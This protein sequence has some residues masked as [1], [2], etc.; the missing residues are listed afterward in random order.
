MFPFLSRIIAKLYLVLVLLWITGLILYLIIISFKIKKKNFNLK[1]IIISFVIEII[2]LIII[3]SVLP[4]EYYVKDSIIYTYGAS[5]KFIY[6]LCFLY[7]IIG[8]IILILNIKNI[9]DNRYIPLLVLVV[10]GG[11]SAII[12]MIYPGLLLATSVHVFITF[13]MYFTIENPDME[14][15]NKL[16][17][18]YNQAEESNNIKSDFLSSM[19]H[20]INTPLNAI[21]GFSQIMNDAK[22]LKEA[23]ENSKYVL[24]ASFTLHNM[25]KNAIDLMGI[26]NNNL[27]IEFEKY[28][29]KSEINK[30]VSLYKKRVEDKN[31]RLNVK[32]EVPKMLYG[33][34]KK[35]RR[36]IANLLD[37]AIKYTDEGSI[38][39]TINSKIENSKCEL[40][41]IVKD[42]GTGIDEETQKHLFEYFEREKKYVNG[43]K[44]GMGLGLPI[45]KGLVELL[46]GKIECNSNEKGTTFNIK[47]IQRKG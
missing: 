3:I 26:G 19:S 6:S 47:I 1:L 28:D 14:M 21:M 37:N 34:K 12:Q 22:T 29:L 24:D 27:S 17:L 44:S 4:I 35:V 8:I 41:I 5:V 7:T 38:Y 9:A 15:L 33:D 20:E 40:E 11:T 30:L 16:T 2:I 36:I 25:L 32:I 13:L 23:K 46:D 10:L 43:N 18:A 39:L 31:L 42:T 45:V